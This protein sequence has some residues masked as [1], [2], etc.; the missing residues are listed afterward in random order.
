MNEGLVRTVI[1]ALQL[2]TAIAVVRL[3]RKA[4]ELAHDY[5]CFKPFATQTEP[6]PQ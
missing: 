5:R 3:R 1:A 6:Q 2:P 4:R